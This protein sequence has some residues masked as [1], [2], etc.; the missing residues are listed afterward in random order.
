[1][2][3]YETTKEHPDL[4][5]KIILTEIDNQY[6]FKLG[7]KTFFTG[8]PCIKVWI[9]KGYIKEVQKK[10]FT[11]DDMLEFARFYHSRNFVEKGIEIIKKWQTA[12]K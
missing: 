7:H 5:E 11:P 12:E 10:E 4:K 8:V 9:S 2:K 1:M 3:K 6:E